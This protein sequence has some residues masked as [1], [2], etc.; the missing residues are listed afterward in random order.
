MNSRRSL[1]TAKLRGQKTIFKSRAIAQQTV[2]NGC[3]LGIDPSL[4]GSGFSVV[5]IKPDASMHYLESLTLKLGQKKSFVECL[6]EIFKATDAFFEKYA[7]KAVGIE[8]TIYVQ[9]SK[10]AHI[11][12]SARGACLSAVALRNVPVQ[13]FAPLRIKKSV[14]GVGQATKEQVAKMVQQLLNLPKTLPPDESDA[15][16]A[17][18]CYFFSLK[19]LIV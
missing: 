5:E 19:S 4:R 6:G 11:L 13:E 12:G 9:N 3:I 8:Q 18:L 1:W 14:T 15:T 7:I 2:F 16:A 17:A 10:T